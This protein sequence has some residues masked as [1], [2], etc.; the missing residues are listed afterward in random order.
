MKHATLLGYWRKAV[1]KLKGDNCAV[2]GAP[3]AMCHHVIRVRRRL[4]AY[5]VRNCL[6]LCNECHKKAHKITGWERQFISDEDLA[7]IEER[8]MIDLK[9]YFVAEGLTPE[10]W[11]AKMSVRLRGIIN[12]D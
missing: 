3:Y 9:D 1:H 10:E 8:A 7:Y 11:R 5:D 6:L 12:D 4:L 2:C